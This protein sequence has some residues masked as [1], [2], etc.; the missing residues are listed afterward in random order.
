[1]VADALKS[2]AGREICGHRASV[3]EELG[4]SLAVGTVTAFSDFLSFQL[5]TRL[6]T[7]YSSCTPQE[8]K[9]HAGMTQLH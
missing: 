1:M 6:L 7:S 5:A 4:C 2:H 3:S 8:F 9:S